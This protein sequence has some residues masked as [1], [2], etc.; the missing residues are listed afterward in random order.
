M[1]EVRTNADG[2][3]GLEGLVP[4]E[5]DSANEGRSLPGSA[6][7]DAGSSP[8]LE[9]ANQNGGR[10]AEHGA[11]QENAPEA[12]EA[13]DGITID[14]GN[15]VMAVLRKAGGRTQRNKEKRGEDAS[16]SIAD[17]TIR[18]PEVAYKTFTEAIAL[19]KKHLPGFLKLNIDEL[20][21]QRLA[22]KVVG[23]S[24]EE[25]TIIDP[26]MLLHPV[27]RL[28]T[29]IFHERLH[30]KNRVPNEGL[31]HSNTLMYFQGIETPESYNAAVAKFE[32]FA[33]IFGNG[34]IRKG[35]TAI[36][37][38]YYKASRSG[39]AKSYE[40]IYAKFMNRAKKTG[41]FD[42]AS[43]QKF[44]NE[45]FPELKVVRDGDQQPQVPAV[46]NQTAP[47]TEKASDASVP[48]AGA[49]AASAERDAA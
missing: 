8:D 18:D 19:V 5:L 42:E 38:L 48:P 30:D 9:P 20:M 34:D 49:P 44:F 46:T 26:E 17:E 27:M 43:A 31:V 35:A 24:R 11:G 36:Y 15:E 16:V 23:R 12:A 13:V 33:S 21:F 32:R 39:N 3:D 7:H 1:A 22:G 37:K 45:V 47:V 10:G 29:V 40:K 28:G 25:G 14:K 6:E 2:L 41:Y 4:R